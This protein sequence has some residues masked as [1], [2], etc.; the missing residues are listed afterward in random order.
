MFECALQM[1]A[2]SGA[3][4]ALV[5]ALAARALHT[6]ETHRHA[7]GRIVEPGVIKGTRKARAEIKG[8]PASAANP[9]LNKSPLSAPLGYVEC[10]APAR[11]RVVRA[12]FRCIVRVA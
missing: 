11:A 2:S 12:C 3:G 10:V 6:S 9:P 7:K 4:G 8:N 5:R 1:L